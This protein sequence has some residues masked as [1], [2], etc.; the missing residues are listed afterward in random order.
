MH[1]LLLSAFISSFLK[2]NEGSASDWCYQSQDPC[3]SR[4]KGPEN[5]KDSVNGRVCAGKSQSPIN[6]V[7]KRTLFD[8][9]LTPLKFEGYQ[10][11]F[12]SHMVNNG[13]SVKVD[14]ATSATISGGNLS[15]VY[16]AVQFHLHWGKDG[17]PGSEH[18]VDGEQYPMELHI[19]HMKQHYASLGDALKDPTGVAV[20]GFFY[21]ESPSANKNY[22]PFIKALSNVKVTGT[23]TTI[24]IQSLSSLLP[25]PKNL[26]SYFRYKGSLT[27]PGCVESVVW[28]VFEHPILLNADQL[29]AFSA[30]KFKDGKPMVDTFRPVQ[31]L[32]GRK[33]YRSA[34]DVV[35]ASATLLAVSIW[36]ALGLSWPN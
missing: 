25:S 2:I 27:T 19:V 33:V 8:D 3:S 31:P 29:K 17:G 10:N 11:A 20:L 18:T 6:I 14:V 15:S 12:N 24:H 13:H 5:W 34:S 23:N 32:H 9:L 4:C 35:L 28:T 22:E 36:A 26:T 7:T 1:L 21:E 30:V 16:K